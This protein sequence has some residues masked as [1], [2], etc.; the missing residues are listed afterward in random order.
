MTPTMSR[1]VRQSHV[2]AR[3]VAGETVLIPVGAP[4]VSPGSSGRR[5]ADFFLL[6]A[7]AE[8]L[9]ESLVEARSLDELVR[10][11]TK[12]FDI[13]PATAKADVESFLA[14]LLA[15]EAVSRVEE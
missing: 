1:F 4:K 14:S 13:D 9:W 15:I 10:I 3:R 6:N 8:M 2:V 5:T 7:S 12:E 11:L